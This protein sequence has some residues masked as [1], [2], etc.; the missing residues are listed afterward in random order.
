[1]YFFAG[2]ASNQYHRGAYVHPNAAFNQSVVRRQIVRIPAGGEQTNAPRAELAKVEAKKLRLREQLRL[3]EEREEIR[4]LREEIQTVERKNESLRAEIA[5]KER[6]DRRVTTE[7]GSSS[8]N[9]ALSSS[10]AEY[11]A[12]EDEYEEETVVVSP[13]RKRKRKLAPLR[14]KRRASKRK[15][16]EENV[17]E[18]PR[19]KLKSGKVSRTSFGKGSLAVL[20]DFWDSHVDSPYPNGQEKA[21]LARKAQ[22]TPLQVQDCLKH[23]FFFFWFTVV[24]TGFLNRRK[25]SRRSGTKDKYL[26]INELK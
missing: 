2:N 25:R 20:I 3:R 8:S 14:R 4:H 1:M 18:Q 16:D 11:S 12:R 13:K 7:D 5:A 26:P 21:D 10:S 17:D 24:W 9:P 6:E 22:L 15:R 19:K 23:F